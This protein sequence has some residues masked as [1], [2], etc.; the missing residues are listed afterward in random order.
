MLRNTHEHWRTHRPQPHGY[1]LQGG[2]D[3]VSN[4][5]VSHILLLWNLGAASIILVDNGAGW[6]QLSF[7]LV[8]GAFSNAIMTT[9]F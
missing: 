9:K 2:K 8:V 1:H 5:R 4:I 6:P 7:A 3:R